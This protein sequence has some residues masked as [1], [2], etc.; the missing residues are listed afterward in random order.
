MDVNVACSV[1]NAV[2]HTAEE[3]VS[4]LN[5]DLH[6]CSSE[7]VDGMVELLVRKDLLALL[8][9][10][11]PSVAMATFLRRIPQGQAKP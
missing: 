8:A 5:V 6:S 10:S 7:H 2:L 1:G 3:G 4:L 9:T 11:P